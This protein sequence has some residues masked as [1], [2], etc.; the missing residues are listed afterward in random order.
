MLLANI[1]DGTNLD[2]LIMRN[3]QFYS[4]IKFFLTVLNFQLLHLT[5]NLP[6]I[7]ALNYTRL[8]RLL[9]S[10]PPK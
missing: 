8:S 9:K 2:E 3:K 10:T 6:F 5:V 4:P 1:N 7:T